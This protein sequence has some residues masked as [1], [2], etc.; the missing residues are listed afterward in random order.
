M[1]QTNYKYASWQSRLWKVRSC[2]N[3]T[4]LFTLSQIIRAVNSD[5]L[6][7]RIEKKKEK[8]RMAE[9]PRPLVSFSLQQLHLLLST[10]QHQR[11][12]WPGAGAR[13]QDVTSD[14]KPTSQT[15]TALQDA[16]SQLWEQSRGVWHWPGSPRVPG[17]TPSLARPFK[18]ALQDHVQALAQ[19]RT[20]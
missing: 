12:K 3:H 2:P 18:G 5:D 7:P 17:W 11:A 6:K 8:K 20:F 10:A 19:R 9:G 1:I 16:P 14:S 4:V 15:S 13:G